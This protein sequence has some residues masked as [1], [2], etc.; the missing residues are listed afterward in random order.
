MTGVRPA[1]GADAGM[2]AELLCELGY[3]VTAD[4]VGRRL[5]S[6]GSGDRVLV[7]EDGAGMVAAHRVPLLAEGG[8]LLRITALAVRAQDR[9]RGVATAMLR[10][11]EELAR[12][13]G[14]SVIEVSSSRRPERDAA[15]RLYPSAG[16]VDASSQAVRYWKDLEEFGP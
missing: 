10:A 11:A 12:D 2:V 8:A 6:L 9:G 14:C 15:H 4:E 5:G 7:A 3:P 16:F 1:D 13:W